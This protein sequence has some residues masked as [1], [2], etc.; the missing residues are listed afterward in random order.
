MAVRPITVPF[1]NAGVVR[2][3]A[4]SAIPSEGPLPTPWAMNVRLEDSLT[5][6]LRGGSFVGID[7]PDIQGSRPRYLTDDAGNI[8]ADDDGRLFVV[9]SE[10][11]VTA[12]GGRVW[13]VAG[14][15]S[16]SP[17]PAEAI[18]RGR[19]LRPEGHVIYASR[20][21]DY[22][23]WNYGAI[24]ED[25]TKAFA[26]QLSEGGEIG[27]DVT[28]LIPHKDTFLLAATSDSLWS[29]QGDPAGDG[30]M[31]NVARGVGIIGP[32]SWCKDH[33]DRVF[34][35]A[36]DGFYT[37]MASGEGLQAVSEDAVPQE[38]A[39]ITDSETILTYNHSDRGVY[40]HV[41]GVDVSW[42]FDTERR[43]FWPFRTDRNESHVLLGPIKLAT[44]DDIG[45]LSSV[46][47]IIAEGSADVTWRVVTGETAE[48]AASNG[49]AAI[50][51]ALASLSFAS[52]VRYGGVWKP[53]RSAT[54]HPRVRSM[55]AC[56]W[57]SSEGEWA[58]EKVTMTLASVGAWRG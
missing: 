49:K 1:P 10:D 43:N 23:D 22:N 25:P 17:H 42:F 4:Y 20:Q 39:D 44:T 35:L 27:T 40:I 53:G 55:W 56:L 2:R 32:R 29:I 26:I 18:Y 16:P 19:F 9:D 24:F 13:A 11:S 34:F 47:G 50:E 41:P 15:G 6:R 48:R 33:M 37:V 52:Y 31:R 58:F 5:K 14:I 3:V 38:L 8:I 12:S 7:P 57:L 21:G 54:N 45:V 28:A 51:A 46:H 30:T 36:S